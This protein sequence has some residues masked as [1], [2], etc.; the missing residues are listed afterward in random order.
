MMQMA[1]N[2]QARKTR[3]ETASRHLFL[4]RMVDPTNQILRAWSKH[5]MMDIFAMF[6]CHD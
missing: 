1:D 2:N 3:I 4:K 6:S 5:M